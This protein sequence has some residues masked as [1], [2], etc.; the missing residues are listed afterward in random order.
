M[1]YN[2][3]SP[4]YDAQRPNA[5]WIACQM[6]PLLGQPLPKLLGRRT[7]RCTTGQHPTPP[8]TPLPPLKIPSGKEDEDGRWP[9]GTFPRGWQGHPEDYAIRHWTTLWTYS[10]LYY[11]DGYCETFHLP[12]SVCLLETSIAIHV[13]TIWICRVT[14]IYIKHMGMSIWSDLLK[15]LGLC[16]RAL[17][18]EWLRT[19]VGLR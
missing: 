1:S 14:C 15:I 4:S 8:I 3:Q 18:V 16:L 17:G 6:S 2:S 10:R 13:S 19:E 7:E 9:Q 12:W 11:W 5:K